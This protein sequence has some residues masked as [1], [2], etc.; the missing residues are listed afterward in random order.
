MCVHLSLD[1]PS[2]TFNV[3]GTKEFVELAL[4]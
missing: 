3:I 2:E 4:H 1:S